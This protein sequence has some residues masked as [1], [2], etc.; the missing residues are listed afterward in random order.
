MKPCALAV[1]FNPEKTEVLLTKRRDVPLWVLPGGG[2]E[3]EEAPEAAVLREVFEETG[4]TVEIERKSGE[5]YPI[6]WLTSHTHLFECRVVEG[7]MRLSNETC[8]VNFFP[9]SHLPNPLFELHK[10]W[11]N[12]CCKEPKKTVRKPIAQVTYKN[13]FIYFLKH[14]IIVIRLFLARFGLPINS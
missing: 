6:N 11:L 2:I 12:D 9:L 1:V 13:L 5:Y 4:L 14:P 7:L 3:N 10:V 8:N